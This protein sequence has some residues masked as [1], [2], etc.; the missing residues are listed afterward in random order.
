M[1][2]LCFN[3]LCIKK[4]PVT[5]A[6]SLWRGKLLQETSKKKKGGSFSIIFIIFEPL[7]SGQVSGLSL[8]EE[9]APVKFITAEDTCRVSHRTAVSAC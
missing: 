9:G 7:L 3:F 4:T 2:L 1:L 6:T 5:L 8:A